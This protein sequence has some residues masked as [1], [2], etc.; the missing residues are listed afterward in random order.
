MLG[1]VTGIMGLI[2]AVGA[3]Y[4][5]S[6]VFNRLSGGDVEAKV[7]TAL[8]KLA[9]RTQWEATSRLTA[10]AGQEE[11][12]QEEKEEF[13]ESAMYGTAMAGLTPAHKFAGDFQLAE[14]VAEGAGTTPLGLKAATQDPGAQSQ[15]ASLKDY[16][17]E[18][19]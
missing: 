2:L 5:I 7:Q 9:E 1:V 17:R 14:Q 19:A 8:Q 10:Q 6:K 11:Q 15:L 4:G 16:L 12:V 18:T 13:R 3:T